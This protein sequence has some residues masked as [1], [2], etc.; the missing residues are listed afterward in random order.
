MPLFVQEMSE[1]AS[2]LFAP[3]RSVPYRLS[4]NDGLGPAKLYKLARQS[5][6][7][8]WD[9]RQNTVCLCLRLCLCLCLWTIDSD[10]VK[11][12]KNK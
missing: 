5:S 1:E 11:K 10:L 8:P 2:A 7:I 6:L 12:L 9:T 3:P 4:S